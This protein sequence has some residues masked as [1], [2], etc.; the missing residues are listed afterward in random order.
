MKR[1]ERNNRK[2]AVSA[3]LMLPLFAFTACQER[4]E[5]VERNAPDFRDG[6]L[7]PSA[8][9]V[10]PG[11][12]TDIEAAE[13]DDLFPGPHGRHDH[14]FGEEVDGA[15][16]RGVRAVGPGPDIGAGSAQGTRSDYQPSTGPA[17]VTEAPDV[18]LG[19]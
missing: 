11:T 4:E 3:A 6:V 15:E 2:V 14:P 7:D 17:G 18:I 5:G 13:P 9:E 12:G 8:A 10:A 19:E 1:T 16:P